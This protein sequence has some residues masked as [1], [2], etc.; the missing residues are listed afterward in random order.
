MLRASMSLRMPDRALRHHRIKLAS[1]CGLFG[2]SPPTLRSTC[3]GQSQSG[4][5]SPQSAYN[6][7]RVIVAES[8]WRA[9]AHGDRACHVATDFAR[10]RQPTFTRSKLGSLGHDIP[11]A[12][13]GAAFA[14]LRLSCFE[15]VAHDSGGRTLAVKG[16][17]QYGTKLQSAPI[18]KICITRLSRRTNGA[19]THCRHR[20]RST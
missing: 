11:L 6:D 1:R 16:C 19:S 14:D 17:L 15:K 4:R 7:A 8:G 9:L 13:P 18:V 5:H 10:V 3:V 20:V 12:S 2:A